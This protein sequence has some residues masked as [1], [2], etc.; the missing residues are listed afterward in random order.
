MNE[1]DGAS[2]KFV[3]LNQHLYMKLI[4]S[5]LFVALIGMSSATSNAKSEVAKSECC[6]TGAACCYPGSPCCK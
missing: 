4:A 2:V 6:G 5:L 3:T 1:H